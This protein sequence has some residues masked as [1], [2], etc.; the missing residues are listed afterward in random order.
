ML[1]DTVLD[2]TVLDYTVLDNTYLDNT[3]LEPTKLD[4]G[5]F[6]TCL[7]G[8]ATLRSSPCS[9]QVTQHL[10]RRRGDP[11]DWQSRLV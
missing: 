6:W 3:K 9:G 10:P 1:D 5:P 2:D 4:D 7:A 8:L 11:A